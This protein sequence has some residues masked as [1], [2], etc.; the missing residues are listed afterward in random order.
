MTTRELQRLAEMCE[1]SAAEIAANYFKILESRTG[2]RPDSGD[3]EGANHFL[4]AAAQFRILAAR[5]TPRF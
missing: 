5:N 4:S 2:R 1:K 3:I